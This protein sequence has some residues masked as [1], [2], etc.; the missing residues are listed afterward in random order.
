MIAT[1]SSPPSDPNQASAWLDSME[2]AGNALFLAQQ[3]VGTC[4]SRLDQLA[5]SAPLGQTQEGPYWTSR[6]PGTSISRWSAAFESLIEYFRA[7]AD[8][9]YGLLKLPPAGWKWAL[10]FLGMAQVEWRADGAFEQTSI[11]HMVFCVASNGRREQMAAG[12]VVFRDLEE[13]G[14]CLLLT[15]SVGCRWFSDKSALQA[16]VKMLYE[17]E[18]GGALDPSSAFRFL[19]IERNPFTMILEEMLIALRKESSARFEGAFVQSVS[20]EDQQQI[21]WRLSEEGRRDSKLISFGSL[22]E[23]FALGWREAKVARQEEAILT[24]I[25]EPLQGDAVQS[26]LVELMNEG[27]NASLRRL[28][29]STRLRALLR[30]STSSAWRAEA[31]ANFLAC[32][33]DRGLA[34][35]DQANMQFKLGML[36]EKQLTMVHD[37]VFTPDEPGSAER[38]T[39]VYELKLQTWKIAGALVLR[40]EDIPGQRLEQSGVLL[41]MPGLQGGLATFASWEALQQALSA[42]LLFRAQSVFLDNVPWASRSSVENYLNWCL[43]TGDDAELN[44]TPIRGD[45][46]SHS[47]QTQLSMLSS[48]LQSADFLPEDAFVQLAIP[49]NEAQEV[50]LERIADQLRQFPEADKIKAK[51]DTFPQAVRD[52]VQQ[53]LDEYRKVFFAA[54]EQ[55]QQ[56]LPDR[57]D[58]VD[59]LVRERLE[60]DLGLER[61][62]EVK[63]DLPDKVVTTTTGGALEVGTGFSQEFVTAPSEGRSLLSLS[64]LALNNIDDQMQA[65][66][67][68]MVVRIESDIAANLPLARSI[69]RAYII[70]L[71]KTLDAAEKYRARI[72]EAYGAPKDSPLFVRQSRRER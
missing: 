28:A 44:L 22:D 46:L 34:L 31:D 16:Y 72:G 67:N 6:A 60:R 62:F 14:E 37:V 30:K 3:Q 11:P 43:E 68:F 20:Q 15:M 45:A 47:L 4:V 25:G 10:E 40:V 51:F 9:D 41:Y 52:A 49:V 23:D 18:T 64:D 48:D 29:A 12:V 27:S 61:P 55:Q 32:H 24:F 38:L 36:S 33:T 53:T 13:T 5:N 42:T 1:S 66:L 21:Q 54:R 50:A 26:N 39:Q 19:P 58:F 7:R 65:R 35:V 63:L 8:L 69:T 71:I 59:G 17:A 56:D 57:D 2:G 70:D